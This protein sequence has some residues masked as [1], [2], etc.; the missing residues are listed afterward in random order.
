MRNTLLSTLAAIAI[1]TGLCAR[2]DALPAYSRLYQG[3]YGYRAPCELCHT[4]G[5]GSA[6]NDYGRDFLRAGANLPAFGKLEGKDSDGDGIKNLAEITAK[7]NPGD[8]RSVPEKAGAWLANAGQAE[9]PTEDLKKIFPSA[10]SFAALE[11][12]L[13]PEQL[14]AVAKAVGATL[15]DEDR[16]PTFYFAI[17]GGKRFAVAQYVSLQTKAGLTTLAV[18]M[19]TGGTVSG[20]KILKNPASKAIEDATFLAQF[21]GKKR[22]DPLEVGKD[23][24]Q[25]GK[26]A[27]LSNKVALVV[28]KAIATINAVFAK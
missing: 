6:V 16:L 7:A 9:V 21:R 27:E 25:A 5:G 22:G 26:E 17:K 11:G 14:S 3:K 15:V 19:D 13:K 10:D 12:S 1:I 18:A 8:P 23:L 2:A 4:N 24:T 28:R 20:I